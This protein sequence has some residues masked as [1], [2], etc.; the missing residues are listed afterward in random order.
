MVQCV[1]FPRARQRHGTET[2]HPA[3]HLV[4]AAVVRKTIKE[5]PC[6]WFTGLLAHILKNP[7]SQP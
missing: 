2:L 3:A 5:T 7:L 4:T 6:T 1:S